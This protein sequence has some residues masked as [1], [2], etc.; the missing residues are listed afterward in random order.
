MKRIERL[1]FYIRKIFIFPTLKKELLSHSSTAMLATLRR[2][3]NYIGVVLGIVGPVHAAGP[4]LYLPVQ[5]YCYSF[6]AAP[7]LNCTM[8]RQEIEGL[9]DEVNG[10]WKQAGIEW[11]ILSVNHRS[12]D[13]QTF[14]ALTGS[15]DR[16]EMK[17]RFF[18]ASSGNL[19][20]KH[21]WNIAIIREFTL[22]AGGIYFPGSHTVYFAE[23]T[24]R[25]KTLPVVLAHELGHSFGLA[26]S[27]NAYNLMG[28]GKPDVK[29]TLTED[30]ISAVRTQAA[31]GPADLND[32]SGLDGKTGRRKDRNVKKQGQIGS[33]PGSE[34]AKRRQRMLKRLKSFD[35]DGDGI[36]HLTDA[37]TQA[38][39]VFQRIDKNQD[40]KID[41][42]ELAEFE[43]GPSRGGR[44][45]STGADPT[46]RRQRMVKRF[47]SFDHDGDGVI[48]Q[49]DAPAQARSIFQ[50]IDKNQ[51]GKIDE[52]ELTEFEQGPNRRNNSAP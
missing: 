38:R 14:P 25:G 11:N 42:S 39:A 46:Q 12:V 2:A 26:H 50:R 40:G 23:R 10:I 6:D 31:E 32:M 44:G 13:K 47:K 45:S 52:S 20:D 3:L 5:V 19:N 8:T 43:Q 49:E 48:Y 24:P 4:T 16:H 30:Q 33:G 51:D 21:I 35:H 18:A 7:E 22:P 41:E 34:S 28:V 17:Q 27:E 36:I 15:E 1:T 37:P 9:A 29:K